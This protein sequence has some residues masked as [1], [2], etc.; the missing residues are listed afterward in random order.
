MQIIESV[1]ND[2]GVESRIVDRVARSLSQTLVRH[3]IRG[4]SGR[5]E[6]PYLGAALWRGRTAAQKARTMLSPV[7]GRTVNVPARR[8][9]PAARLRTHRVLRET[10]AGMKI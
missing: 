3:L 6:V 1:A 7:L 10:V 2:T 5:V 8:S 4:G 9:Q